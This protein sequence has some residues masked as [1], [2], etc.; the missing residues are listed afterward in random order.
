MVGPPLIQRATIDAVVDAL[1]PNEAP[2]RP[3]VPNEWLLKYQLDITRS[4]ILDQDPDN[5]KFTNGE[6]FAGNSNPVDP[7]SRPNAVMKLKLA[8][9]LQDKCEVRFMANGPNDFQ[10][11]RTR[12]EGNKTSLIPVL[13][14]FLWEDD[15]RFKWLEVKN[16]VDA[17]NKPIKIAVLEDTLVTA[18]S[19]F[20]IKETETVNR[21]TFKAKILC[22]QDNTTDTQ[23]EGKP[24]NFPAFPNIKF[25]LSKINVDSVEIDYVEVGQA[26]QKE[27]IKLNPQNP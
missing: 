1:D 12:E 7:Q 17:E 25:T 10:F 3:P 27:V 22:T 5:D 9:I 23:P 6:E 18:G 14:Q 16:G 19:P 20:E 26:S 24:L 21:P 4:K 2:V 15:K 13:G 11:R 8:E